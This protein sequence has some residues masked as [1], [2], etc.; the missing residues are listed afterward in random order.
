[1]NRH[2]RLDRR[3]RTLDRTAARRKA[4]A[5]SPTWSPADDRRARR[6]PR[7]GFRGDALLPGRLL[8]RADEEVRP[9]ARPLAAR[10]R[11]SCSI[12]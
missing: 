2:T 11:S 12:R 9:P 1:M 7:R 10:R 8:R 4:I 6:R 3:G 5:S